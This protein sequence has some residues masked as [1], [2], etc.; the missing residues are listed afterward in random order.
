[1]KYDIIRFN[2]IDD[3]KGSLIAI[4]NNKNIPFAIKR[5]YYIFGTQENIRRGFHAHK[6]L[7]Q[8]I[9]CIHGSCRILLDD[10]NSQ[11]TLFLD[12]LHNGL[13]VY[14]MI[15]HEMFDFKN[16]CILLVLC[17]DLYD[18]QDYIRNYQQFICLLK[19]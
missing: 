12:S 8:V 7:T 18:E 3:L 9:I 6:K 19:R 4:E 5:L 2:S 16:D 10:G 15:W 14:P 1:M 13:I 11:Q 17:D